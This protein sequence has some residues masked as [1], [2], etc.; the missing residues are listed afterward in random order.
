MPAQITDVTAVAEAL[1]RQT[2]AGA[3]GFA[4]RA[5][6]GGRRSTTE[7]PG[8]GPNWLRPVGDC[9]RRDAGGQLSSG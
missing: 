4:E 9:G 6:S 8:S 2:S 3:A 7:G 1:L 5:T